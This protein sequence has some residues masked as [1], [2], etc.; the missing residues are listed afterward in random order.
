M[1]SSFELVWTIKLLEIDGQLLAVLA[2][3]GYAHPQW[4]LFGLM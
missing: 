1:D 4:L 2:L 3:S